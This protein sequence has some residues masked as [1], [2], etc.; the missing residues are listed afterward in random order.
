MI[1]ICGAI[2]AE[3]LI[4]ANQL[5]PLKTWYKDHGVII[6]TGHGESMAGAA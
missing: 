4:S 5:S 2:A 6:V 1:G 3:G